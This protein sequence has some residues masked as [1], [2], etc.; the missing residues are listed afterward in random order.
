MGIGIIFTTL[1]FT[2]YNKTVNMSNSQI[3][4]K[5]RGLGMVYPSEVKVLK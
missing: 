1:I 2:G 5:A 3:E 4:D